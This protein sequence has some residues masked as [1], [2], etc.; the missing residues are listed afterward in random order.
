ME[1]HSTNT[2]QAYSVTGIGFSSARTMIR[3]TSDTLINWKSQGLLH[4]D[5]NQMTN[6]LEWLWWYCSCQSSGGRCQSTY[7]D[8]SGKWNKFS[9]IAKPCCCFLANIFLGSRSAGCATCIWLIWLTP[10]CKCHDAAGL[11]NH[12]ALH[13]NQC[14]VGISAWY[15]ECSELPYLPPEHHLCRFGSRTQLEICP[16]FRRISTP[17]SNPIYTPIPPHNVAI[18]DAIR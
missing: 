12:S 8:L 16:D 13:I 3:S 6:I 15:A 4:P 7:E 1:I 14:R 2:I 11:K 17:F 5:N 9:R 10:I 18:Y